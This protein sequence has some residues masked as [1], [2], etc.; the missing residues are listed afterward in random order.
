MIDFKSL[1][2]NTSF[3]NIR[4]NALYLYLERKKNATIL[5]WYNN[6]NLM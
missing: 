2:Y 3:N 6:L 1:P 4:L 5:E